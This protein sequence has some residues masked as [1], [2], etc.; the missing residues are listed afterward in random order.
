MV[1]E[2]RPSDRVA[3]RLQGLLPGDAGAEHLGVG[4]HLTELKAS[5][6]W[7]GLSVR[8]HRMPG[9]VQET[10]AEEGRAENEHSGLL[11]PTPHSRKKSN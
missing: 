10:R 7:V 3:A 4:H 6:T 2:E 1:K 8:W 5:T 9:P 11:D